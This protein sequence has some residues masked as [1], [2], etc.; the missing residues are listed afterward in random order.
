MRKLIIRKSEWGRDQ[1]C[2]GIPVDYEGPVTD[3]LEPGGRYCC[4]GLLLRELGFTDQDMAYKL[5]PYSVIEEAPH[6]GESEEMLEMPAAGTWTIVAL[7]DLVVS[8]PDAGDAQCINDDPTLAPWQ[9][10]RKLKTIFRRNGWEI[11]YQAR[12]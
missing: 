12:E 6:R 8:S 3:L 5:M 4:L 2:S 1:L 10:I 7:P 9:K 11:D